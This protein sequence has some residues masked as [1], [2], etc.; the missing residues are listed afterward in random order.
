V[1]RVDRIEHVAVDRGAADRQE[2]DAAFLHAATLALGFLALVGGECAEVVVEGCVA[3][4]MPME[5]Y[6]AT[7]EPAGLAQR[8]V[9]HCSGEQRVNRRPAMLLG[10]VLQLVD[11]SAAQHR[12]GR[13]A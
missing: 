10:G 5:L 13:V 8:Y 1:Q 6:V 3:A 2:F 12:I 4:I 9:I 11:Q 7:R